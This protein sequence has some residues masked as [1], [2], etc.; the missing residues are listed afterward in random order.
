M[1][2]RPKTVS[3]RVRERDGGMCTVPGCSRAA[4]DSHHV[5]FR[6]RGGDVMDPA[7]QTSVC[8][9]HHHR[10]IHAEHLHARG[11]A[12]DELTWILGGTVFTGG[13]E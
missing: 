12:P 3:Q 13:V 8:E 1:P 10:C 5:V 7:N 9:F 2:L 6:S 11:S 4:T